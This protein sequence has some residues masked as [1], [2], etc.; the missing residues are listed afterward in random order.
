MISKRCLPID[1]RQRCGEMQ[2]PGKESDAKRYNQA[3]KKAKGIDPCKLVKLRE[4]EM[5][6][7]QVPV[8]SLY[9]KKEKTVQ[10]LAQVS[11]QA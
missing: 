6:A 7:G 3:R 10:C 9:C 2:N 11:G 5:T 8:L 1:K 4:R